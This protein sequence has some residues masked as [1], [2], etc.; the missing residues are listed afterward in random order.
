MS[1]QI[2][3]CILYWHKIICNETINPPKSKLSF[4]N[5]RLNLKAWL[6]VENKNIFVILNMENKSKVFFTSMF[7]LF[8]KLGLATLQLVRQKRWSDGGSLVEVTQGP[9]QK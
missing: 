5:L 8:W 2:N 4:Y 3:E 7:Y 1:P 6:N 9:L